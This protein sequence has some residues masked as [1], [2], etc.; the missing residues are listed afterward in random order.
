MTVMDWLSGIPIQSR[1]EENIDE[2]YRD[3][4]GSDGEEEAA[5]TSW[6]LC[7]VCHHPRFQRSWD[8]SEETGI[9]ILDDVQIPFEAAHRLLFLPI[10]EMEDQIRTEAKK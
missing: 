7:D 5:V 2:S 4:E 10:E 1:D 3:Q 8:H 9:E 6:F